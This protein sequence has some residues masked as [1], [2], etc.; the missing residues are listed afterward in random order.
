MGRSCSTHRRDEKQIKIL[1]GKT[2]WKRRL[3]RSRCRWNDNM[4]MDL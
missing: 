2:E 1:V 3:G 4:K